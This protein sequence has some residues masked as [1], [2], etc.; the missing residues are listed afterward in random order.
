MDWLQFIDSMT[1]RLAWPVAVLVL[2]VLLRRQII[3]LAERIQEVTFPGGSA[4]FK[5]FEKEL[6]RATDH[7]VKVM[8]NH[9]LSKTG[10]FDSELQFA[11]K[12]PSSAISLAYHEIEKIIQRMAVEILRIEETNNVVLAQRLLKNDYIDL[13][14]YETFDGLRRA[15]NEVISNDRQEPTESQAIVF[16]QQAQILF[17]TLF[18]IWQKGRKKDK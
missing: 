9:Q 1:G 2:V 17:D 7:A 11:K 15:R 8:Q 18:T 13:D 6:S 10:A 12:S 5:E 3:A 4:K 14:I 16:I